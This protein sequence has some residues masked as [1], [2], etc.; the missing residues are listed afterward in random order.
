MFQDFIGDR[1]AIKKLH[2]YDHV[3][4]YKT[5]WFYMCYSSC[6]ERLR[7]AS[8]FKPFRHSYQHADGQPN[9]DRVFSLKI[10][11]RTENVYRFRGMFPRS[12]IFTGP[13]T[14]G[15]LKLNL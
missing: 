10:T 6:E 2:A 7:S 5:F 14:S 12:E 11:R 3:R 9:E 13:N 1:L 8:G 4:T 15:T